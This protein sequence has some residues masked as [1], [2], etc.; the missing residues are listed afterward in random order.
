MLNLAQGDAQRRAVSNSVDNGGGDEIVQ[1]AKAIIESSSSLPQRRIGSKKNNAPATDLTL[2]EVSLADAA[3]A[4]GLVVDSYS[5]SNSRLTEKNLSA[6]QS[7]IRYVREFLAKPN[8]NLGRKGPVCPF[9]PTSLKFDCLYFAVMTREDVSD[10]D[11]LETM[12][13]AAIDTFKNLEPKSGPKATFKAIIF[14]FPDMEKADIPVM[15]DAL[16]KKLKP[17]FVEEGLMLGE[18]HKGNN[19]TGL[20]NKSF[21]PL[22]TAYPCLAIR[23]MV[24][25]DIAFL[26]PVEFPAAVRATMIRTF[27]RKFGDRSSNDQQTEVARGLLNE[28]SH[29]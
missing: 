16:Q 14:I 18:F 9:V 7:I 10:V 11:E 17:I 26:N 29:K 6:V 5:S 2:S 25:S 22:R 12:M 28:L 3:A 27:L 23:H 21:F 13:V 20:R 24:P 19:A 15:I 4:E 8:P 1:T